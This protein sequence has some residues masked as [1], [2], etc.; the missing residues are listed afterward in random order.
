MKKGN[1]LSGRKRNEKKK[2]SKLLTK[3]HAINR[4]VS[5]NSLLRLTIFTIR[6]NSPLATGVILNV[7]YCREIVLVLLHGEDIGYIVKGDYPQ[8]K[9]YCEAIKYKDFS[10]S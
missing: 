7:L 5:F 8:T 9:V 1:F 3:Q 4:D 2:K 10:F 6:A